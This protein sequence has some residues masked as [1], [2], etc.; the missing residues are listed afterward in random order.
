[1]KQVAGTILMTDGESTQFLVTRDDKTGAYQF[2]KTPVMAGKTALAS[3]LEQMRD[4]LAIEL[5]DLRLS[6]L[7]TC[8]VNHEDISL[9]VFD[10]LAISPELQDQVIK[11]GLSFVDGSQLHDLFHDVKIDAAPVFD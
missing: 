11:A 2:F 6:E 1:M 8:E 3:I 4:L 10:H 7:T 9:F 5:D